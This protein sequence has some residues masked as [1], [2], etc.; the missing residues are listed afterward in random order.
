MSISGAPRARAFARRTA[1]HTLR[2][3]VLAATTLL[4]AG[5]TDILEA[6]F[7]V[8]YD[9]TETGELKG[10]IIVQWIDQDKFEFL[11]DPAEPLVFKRRS[12]ETITPARMFTDGGSVPPALRSLKSY[13][14]WGYAPAFIIHDWLFVMAQCKLPGHDQ[15]DVDKAATIMA[16]AMKTVMENPKFGGP[17]K[18]V[19]YSMYQ[20]VRT[21]TARDYWNN[22][23][24]EVPATGGVRAA[25][26]SRS[27]APS[28]ATSSNLPRFTIS[29]P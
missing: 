14:P 21:Q 22:G 19:H 3:V 29:F 18:L 1:G 25:T 28:G 8:L 23:K 24:C 6:T 5:C 20:A 4:V 2:I 15:F 27:M 7:G 16:E 11:P 10:K 26:K 12:G 9:R 13:S 17:K